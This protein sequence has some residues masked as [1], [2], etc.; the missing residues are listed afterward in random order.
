MCS[1]RDCVTKYLPIAAG[2]QNV[3]RILRHCLIQLVCHSSRVFPFIG[4]SQLWWLAARDKN[5]LLCHH[6][7]KKRNKKKGIYMYVCETDLLLKIEFIASSQFYSHHWHSASCMM[8]LFEFHV[9]SG[10]SKF[11]VEKKFHFFF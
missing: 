7:N 5:T 10:N 4:L 6:T 3:F 8:L 1:Q 9:T 2:E 11:G